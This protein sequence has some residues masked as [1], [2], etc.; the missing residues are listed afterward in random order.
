MSEQ[1]DIAEAFAVLV[2]V[3]R[4][5]QKSDD[6]VVVPVVGKRYLDVLSPAS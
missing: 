3:D 4:E 2:L 6:R 5:H 1:A